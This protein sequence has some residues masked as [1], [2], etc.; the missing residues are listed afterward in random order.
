MQKTKLAPVACFFIFLFIYGITS[1]ADLQVSDEIAVFSSGVSLATKGTIN[2]DSLEWLQS[3]V[4]IGRV[5]S[6]GHLYTKYF[7]GNILGIAILYKFAQKENDI[8]FLW[9]GYANRFE[10]QI[11]ARSNQGARIALRWN[12]LLGS[13]G[14]AIL[15]A[16][17]LRRFDWKTATITVL[18]FGLCTDWWYQSRGLFSEIGAGH[19]SFSV[20]ILQTLDHLL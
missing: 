3:A 12:A 14:I 15:Y 11:L 13:M 1:R 5:D 8:P 19:S 18:I 2:I 17:L 16:F 10:P 7:P 9:Q 20:Y 6:D 4:N